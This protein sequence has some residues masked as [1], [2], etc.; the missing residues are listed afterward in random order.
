MEDIEKIEYLE[1][2]EILQDLPRFFLAQLA[3]DSEEKRLKP[4]D[5]LFEEGSPGQ[6]M[7]FILEGELGVYKQGEYIVSRG[8]NE[9]FGEMALIESKPRS[10]TVKSIKDT[11]LLEIDE[12]LFSTYFSS[13]SAVVMKLLKTLSERSRSELESISNKSKKIKSV[14]AFDSLTGLL[15]RNLLEDRFSMAV[16]RANR[17][18][19]KVLFLYLDLK[20]IN[21]QP[22]FSDQEISDSIL[23]EAVNRLSSCLRKEDSII[24]LSNR[25]FVLLTL[26]ENAGTKDALFKKIEQ[27][28]KPA[29]N[30][31]ETS[32][33]LEPLIGSSLFPDEHQSLEELLKNALKEIQG[34]AIIQ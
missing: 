9:F 15:N 20:V 6:T 11:L 32:F 12:E 21:P 29:I 23:L 27:H 26:I 7:Y 28:L 13:N 2:F 22:D 5:V 33:E 3:K 10:A 18:K 19:A 1:K 16:A 4:G 17:E 24:R 34:S 8:A 14:V 31:D 25:E 30:I